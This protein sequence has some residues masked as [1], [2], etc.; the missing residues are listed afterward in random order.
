MPGVFI[1]YRRE[2]TAPYAGRIFDHLAAHFGNDH[3]FFDVDDMMPGQDF[4]QVLDQTLKASNAVVVLI[5]RAWLSAVDEHGHRRIDRHGDYVRQEIATAISKSV[6]VIPV[7]VGRATMPKAEELPRSLLPLARSH[8]IEVSDTRFR[9]DVEG[10]IAAIGNFIR[11]ASPRLELRSEP[12]TLSTA[13][14]RIMLVR[15][16]FYC[17]GINEAGKGVSNQFEQKVVGD[18]LVVV[19]HATRLMWEKI[20]SAAAIQGDPG[21]P[22]Y[23]EAANDKKL[24]GCTGWRLPTLEEG[25]SIMA[26]NKHGAYHLDPVFDPSA[27]MMWTADLWPDGKRWLIYYADGSCGIENLSFHAYIRLVR[28]VRE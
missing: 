2:D 22:A 21:A 6:P 18:Q 23:A 28:G 3:V 8:A 7:L 26:P 24:A 13:E 15:R 17:A 11:T 1:C 27:A 10:L 4:V 9:Q 12:A 14:A 16:D 20:G 19:D 5:G 25:M